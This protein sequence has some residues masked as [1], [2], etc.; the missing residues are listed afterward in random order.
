MLNASG[1]IIAFRASCHT[2]LMEKHD[3]SETKIKL[4][5]ITKTYCTVKLTMEIPCL[6]YEE[7][8]GRQCEKTLK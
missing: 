7:N 3:F 8:G 2:E 5:A 4:L 6:C 1:G